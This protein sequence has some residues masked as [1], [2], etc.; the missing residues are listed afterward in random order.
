MEQAEEEKK[1]GERRRQELCSPSTNTKTV[2]PA[3]MDVLF[4]GE[5]VGWVFSGKK[6]KQVAD[7]L[8][9]ASV[10]WSTM[11]VHQKPE[12]SGYAHAQESKNI[13]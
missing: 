5:G 12:N 11:G 7:Y 8:G 4:Q 13:S 10:S 3:E 9:S 6:K 1:T 2:P